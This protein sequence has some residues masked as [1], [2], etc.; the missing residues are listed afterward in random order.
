MLFPLNSFLEFAKKKRNESP[1]RV[2]RIWWHSFG[3]WLKFQWFFGEKELESLLKEGTQ[4]NRLVPETRCC[5]S[6]S[7]LIFWWWCLPWYL[8]PSQISCFNLS[9]EW[10]GLGQQSIAA[11]LEDSKEEDISCFNES[12]GCPHVQGERG[13]N[14]SRFE[15]ATSLF[16]FLHQSWQHFNPSLFFPKTNSPFFFSPCSSFF[17]KGPRKFLIAVWLSEPPLSEN[18]LLPRGSQEERDLQGSDKVVSSFLEIGI[19]GVASCMSSEERTEETNTNA[20]ECSCWAVR[21]EI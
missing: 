5:L 17:L 2:L 13:I 16:L 9:M 19:E 15:F 3:N 6:P 20:R 8:L 21:K 7:S 14:P 10:E 11:L 1:E 18:L 4:K 12:N